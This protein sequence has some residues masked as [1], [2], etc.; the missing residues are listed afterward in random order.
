[1][2]SQPEY[3]G[4]RSGQVFFSTLLKIGVARCDIKTVSKG[5]S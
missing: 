2:H 5:H 1:M 4:D 3:I